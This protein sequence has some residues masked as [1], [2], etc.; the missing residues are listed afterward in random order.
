M[1]VLVSFLVLPV[2]TEAQQTQQAEGEQEIVL[3]KKDLPP[4]LLQQ[5]ET[6]QQVETLKQRIETY[7]SWVGLGK[8]VGTAMNESL[9]ALTTQA[10]TFSK[11][12]VGQF[13]MFIVAWKV[14]GSD[15]LGVLIGVPLLVLATCIFVWSYRKTCLPYSVLTKVNEDKTREY[16]IVN[17]EHLTSKEETEHYVGLRWAHIGVYVV[18]VLVV[19][20]F[21]I[22]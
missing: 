1:W 6:R 10:D 19:S 18:F 17:Q 7:G 20:G 5:I 4:A 16:T 13:T 14:L 21:I 15:F 11:T 3:K 9:G 12:G 2:S 22:F 8:E